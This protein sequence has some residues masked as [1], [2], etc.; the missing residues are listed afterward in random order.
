[1]LRSLR[2]PALEPD[3]LALQCDIGEVT[4]PLC[5]SVLFKKQKEKQPNTYLKR[6]LLRIKRKLLK[7]KKCLMHTMCLTK[8]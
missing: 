3:Y 5:A 7:R 4:S 2:T 8:Y 1:M 6:L